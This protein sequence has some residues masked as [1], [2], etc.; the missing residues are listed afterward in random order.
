[1]TNATT[2]EVDIS[3]Q[4]M[5]V[6]LANG[7][8]QCYPI[9]SAKNGPGEQLNSECT[10]R[11]LHRIAEKIGE[12]Q[13]ENTVFVGRKPTGEIYSE[14]FAKDQPV[15]DWILTR[16]MWLQGCEQGR[17]LGGDVDSKKRYIY[18]HGTPDSTSLRIP[19]S[20]GCIRMANKDII[21]LFD[22]VEVGTS[23]EIVE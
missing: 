6:F 14:T 13:P 7:E 23:V 8:M 16:I 3:S 22:H 4:Q 1:M 12:G 15:R 2:I 10:P 20:R 11:G 5:T 17:N 19:G 18:I 9:S 21:E